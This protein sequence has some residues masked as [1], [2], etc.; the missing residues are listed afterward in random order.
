[1]PSNTGVNSCVQ[2]TGLFSSCWQHKN[3]KHTI[4]GLP[5]PLRACKHVCTCFDKPGVGLA[6]QPSYCCTPRC[7]HVPTVYAA[8]QPL[9]SSPVPLPTSA[10]SAP[11]SRMMASSAATSMAQDR[12]FHR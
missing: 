8:L 7:C 6:L 2:A 11:S 4:S 1:M 12:G 10:K 3:L 5:T 9:G